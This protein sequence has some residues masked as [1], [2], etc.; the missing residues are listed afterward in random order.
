MRSL[1]RLGIVTA[2][3]AGGACSLINR[4]D[5]VISGTG[6]GGGHTA[7][8]SSSSASSAT[9]TSTSS[10]G[11]G[12]SHPCQVDG[13]CPL[14]PSACERYTCTPGGTCV[15]GPLADATP[16]DDGFFCTVGDVC[17]SGVCAGQPRSCPD[18]DTCNLGACDEKAQACAFAMGNEG[19]PCDDGNP[20]DGPG[21]CKAGVCQKG[22]DACAPLATECTTATCT[23]TGC[24]TQNKLDGT[25]CGM[26]FCSNGVCQ[27]G[28]CNITPINE[29]KPCND[30]LYCTINETCKSGFC[31]GAPNPCP[32]GAA[33]VKG[34]CDEASKACVMTPIPDNGA[35]DDGN[36]CHANA[37]CS[38]SVC[39]GGLAPTVLFSETFAD[40]GHGWTLG[41]EWQIGHATKSFGQDVGFGDPSTD[42]TGE[43]GVAGVEIGGNATVAFPDPN[44]GPYY[45]TSPPVSTMLAGS[46]YLTFYRWLN[47]DYAPYMTDT[48]EVSADGSS[49]T[50]VWQTGTVPITDSA[51]TFQ[52]IDISA[53]K[54]TTTRF[55]FGFSIGEAGVYSVSSWNLDKVKVQNA[56][57]PN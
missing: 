30:G 2:I 32:T 40:N 15:L 51:W 17:K 21:A 22:P 29:G 18:K 11:T 24:V 47:T 57:C 10:T 37:F 3:A 55:R 26:S 46:I 42:A 5:D 33:C 6:G 31:V 7:T 41:P 36:P 44:H 28:H 34:T 50:V 23:P 45:L 54:S 19:K 53:Y 52:A 25:G 39:T 49:W 4:P 8:T 35:C 38:G 27:A 20:C 43:G 12:G 13:D 9:S 56:P 48:V 14:Q 16:C 1:T